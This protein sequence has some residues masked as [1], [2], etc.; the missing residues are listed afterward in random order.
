MYDL[1]SMCIN[2][3]RLYQNIAQHPTLL[4]TGYLG[5]ANVILASTASECLP[6]PS[7]DILSSVSISEY[8]LS[9]ATCEIGNIMTII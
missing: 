4:I 3:Q 9:Q 2:R 8:D 7:V 5:A 1:C 6:L